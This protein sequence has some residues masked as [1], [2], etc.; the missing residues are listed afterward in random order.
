MSNKLSKILIIA[1]ALIACT[2]ILSGCTSPNPTVSITPAPSLAP[3]QTLKLATTTS[4]NDSGLLNYILPDFEKENNVKVQVLSAGTGQALAYGASGDVDVLIVHSPSAEKTFMDQG[5]GW[6]KTQI[7]HNFFVIVGPASDPAGIKGL[8]ATQAY[9]KIAE[10]KANFV[11]RVD[12]SGTDTANKGI[13]NKTSYGVPDNKT[14]T[15]YTASGVG[16]GDALRMANEKQ[17]YALS[18]IGTFLALQKSLDLVILVENDPV[19]LINKYDVIAVN[20]TEHPSV[21]YPMTLK[22]I[23]YLKSQ[24]AQQKIAEYGQAQYGRSLFYAD[25]LNNSTK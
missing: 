10:K 9:T 25:L 4:V 24:P 23:E 3:V 16:M 11:A 18:D 8:N 21:N 2:V 22:F 13:W 17:A 1:I 12:N 5:H 20:Q 6:N 19:T 7:A 14:N 15:W